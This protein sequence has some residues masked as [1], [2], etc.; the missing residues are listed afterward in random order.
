MTIHLVDPKRIK[1]CAKRKQR[2]KILW[3]TVEMWKKKKSTMRALAT[4]NLGRW[5]QA[6]QQH[7]QPKRMKVTVVEGDTLDVVRL[8]TKGYGTMF[9]CINMAN[10]VH[11]GGG[12][13]FGCAAQE[14]NIARRTQLHFRFT[15]SVVDADDCY[16]REMQD[17]INGKHGEVYL[18]TK[19][20][21][22]MRGRE[23]F[24]HDDL[25]Y[26][27]LDDEEIFPFLE[28]RAAA[29]DLRGKR[30]IDWSAVRAEMAERIDAQFKTLQKRGIKHIVLSA[31]GCG[32]FRNDPIMVAELYRDALRRY[33]SNLSVVVFAIFY[34]GHGENNFKIFKETLKDTQRAAAASAVQAAARGGRADNGTA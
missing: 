24:D 21:I 16:T 34:A 26:R 28:L 31:F 4:A 14:E 22:C 3:E 8:C 6:P 11:P 18:S 20:L 27:H 32:A 23:C 7:V 12:Y 9:A 15:D 17:L 25:G 30:R 19:P 5:S 29:V 2:V 10:S 33:Q 13:T 1:G